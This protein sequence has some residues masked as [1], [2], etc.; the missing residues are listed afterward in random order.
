MRDTGLGDFIAR[1][2]RGFFGGAVFAFIAAFVFIGVFDIKSDNVILGVFIIA[3][4]LFFNFY[5]TRTRTVYYVD[6]SDKDPIMLY[7]EDDERI[8]HDD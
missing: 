3:W 8:E 4:L 1:A 6:D 7:P 5:M 2:I